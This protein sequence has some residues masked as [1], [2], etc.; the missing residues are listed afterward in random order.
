MSLTRQKGV[1]T[2][3]KRILSFLLALILMVSA[4][5]GAIAEKEHLTWQTIEE[6]TEGIFTVW[7]ICH[8][9]SYVNIRKKPSGRSETVGYALT[10]WDLLTDGKKKNG[11]LHVYPACEEGEGWV[12][13]K[14]VTY[15]EPQE[16]NC[17]ARI[18]STGRVAARTCIGGERIR[19][20]HED[21][22]VY[23]YYIS[24]WAYTNKGWVKAEFVDLIP[25]I[26][27]PCDPA[28]MTWEEDD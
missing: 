11:F 12:S 16:V 5:A 23:V 3:K 19:W 17:K 8:P 28:E 14:F 25:N 20:L 6:D 9:T 15:E 26:E 2:M 22:E 10:C 27:N 18:V 24:D 7:V 1:Q 4:A 21:D 13:L